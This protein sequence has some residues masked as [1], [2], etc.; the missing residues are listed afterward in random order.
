MPALKNQKHEAFAHA[1]LKGMSADAAYEAAGYK[2]HRGNASRLRTDE[3]IER[4]LKELQETVAEQVIKAVAIDRQWIIETLLRN[5]RICMGDEKVKIARV[6]D[7][8]VTEFEV[9][10]RDA[11]QA[12]AA[13]KLLGQIPEVAIWSEAQAPQVN[14]NVTTMPQAPDTDRIAEICKRF[15]PRQSANDQSAPAKKSAVA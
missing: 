4:R 13:L 11:A 5:A 6:K 8:T 14:V 7:G 10:A 12:N 9:T 2:P 3:S 15:A 1:L